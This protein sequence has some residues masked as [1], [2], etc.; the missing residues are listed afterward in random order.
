MTTRKALRDL[1]ERKLR[2]ALVVLSIAVGV[3]GITAIGLFADQ[4]QRG[5][6]DAVLRSNPPDLAIPTTPIGDGTRDEL[7]QLANVAR[8]DGQTVGT[9]RWRPPG[10]GDREHPIELIGLARFD[11]PAAL[12]RPTLVRGL[13]Q[14]QPSAWPAAGE[15]V[16]ELGARRLYNLQPGAMVTLLDPERGEHRLRVA[17]F[18]EKP[19]V[20]SAQV[21]GQ[22]TAWVRRDD[23]R[24]ILKLDGDNRVLVQLRDRSTAQVREQTDQRVRQ[25]LADA[26]ATLGDSTIRDP[27]RFEGQ[28]LFES[29]RAVSALF[30][31]VGAFASG[32][33]VINTI[34]TIVVEQ[35]GQIG[36][37][38]AVGATTGHVLRLYVALAVLYGVLGTALGLVGALGFNTLGAVLRGLAFDKEPTLPVP[39]REALALGVVVG[40]GVAAVAALLPAWRGAR[41]TIQEAISTYGLAADFGATPWDR[42]LSRLTALPQAAKLASRNLF[43]QPSRALLTVVG[44]TVATAATLAALAAL[45]ALG[46]SFDAASR[47][48]RADLVFHFQ[49]PV[50]TRAV[51]AALEQ[52][53][54]LD[55]AELWLVSRA[56]LAGTRTTVPVKGL[57][58]ASDLLDRGMLR[59]GQWLDPQ[60]PDAVLITRR[61]AERR[62]LAPGDR[63]PV[64]VGDRQETWTVA[65]VVGGAGGDAQAPDGAIY[66]PLAAVRELL[67]LR[68]ALGNTLYVR[69]AD[70]P[71]AAGL[72]PADVVRPE[73]AE[74][75]RRVDATA[76]A[77]GD[78]LAERG[79]SSTTVRLYDEARGNQQAV[80]AIGLL[81]GMVLLVVATVGALGL[82]STLTMNVLERRREIGVMRSLGASTGVLLAT[83]LLE[84][85][86]LGLLGW[87]LGAALGGPAGERLVALLSE[88]LIPLDYHL[89]RGTLVLT[90]ALVLGV[91]FLASLGPALAAARMRI[92]DI[93]R[94]G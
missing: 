40:V 58:P 8:V 59:A 92:A 52:V 1:W 83:Y 57:P 19:G 87:L 6:T 12:D 10:R 7:A 34:T 62:Q 53:A 86:L 18:A 70:G 61:L 82:F 46:R 63:L 15:I 84:G 69:V 93:L 66:A 67:D 28:D 54:E 37:M 49:P 43:R 45:L 50:P 13:G 73:H 22:A 9:A 38:K 81:L 14:E 3:F 68:E 17:G 47:A 21:T 71:A 20:A 56:R 44:L 16:F 31:L 64:E 5:A 35:R 2:T 25:R 77:L 30:A 33:L 36:A 72:A 88:R 85:I 11:D 32:L 23:A 41:T 27:E 91:T 65:G 76:D 90:L 29:L 78:A 48:L 4:V 24:A 51:E 74:R 42:L 94:Y 79:L 80:F 89:P 60:R 75:K 26:G 39:S 55:Q